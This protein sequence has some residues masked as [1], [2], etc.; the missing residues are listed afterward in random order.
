MAASTATSLLLNQ[1][2][3]DREA[4]STTNHLSLPTLAGNSAQMPAKVTSTSE[5]AMS[6]EIKEWGK[7]DSHRKR[8]G[9]SA[10]KVAP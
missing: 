4:G 9:A 1:A 3:A 5:D 7:L 6:P 8:V 10:L 2:M